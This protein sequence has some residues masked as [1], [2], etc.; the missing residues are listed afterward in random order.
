MIQAFLITGIVILPVLS[1]ILILHWRRVAKFSKTVENPKCKA[2]A[3]AMVADAKLTTALLFSL[4]LIYFGTYLVAFTNF[5]EVYEKYLNQIIAVVVIVLVIVALL[6][7]TRIYQRSKRLC[8]SLLK[9]FLRIISDY[10]SKRRFNRI[11]KKLY[12][13]LKENK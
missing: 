4:W 11:S 7:F 9:T 3:T 10:N 12:K 1:I 6:M 2:D 13:P 8:A 5:V